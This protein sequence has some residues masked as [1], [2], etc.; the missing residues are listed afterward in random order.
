M[1]WKDELGKRKRGF[2]TLVITAVLQL[3]SKLEDKLTE[4]ES[5]SRR[6]NIRIYGV[7]EGSEKESTTTTEEDTQRHAEC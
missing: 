1:R 2:K 3:H 4:L 5:C 7:L 6:E